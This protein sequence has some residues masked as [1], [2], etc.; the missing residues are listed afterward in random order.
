[1]SL[2]VS[3]VLPVVHVPF[4]DD[5]SIDYDSL[6]RLIEWAF[7][8]GAS[9][10]CTGMVS[11]LLRLTTA[12]RLELTEK[13]GEFN[14][15][16]GMVVIGSGAEST[17]QAI[18]Y[19]ECAERSGC[20]AVMVIPPISSGL[21][22]DAVREYFG[23]IADAVS[24]PMIVQDA[25]GY[26]GKEIPL[27]VSRDLLERYGEDKVLFKPEASPLGPKLSLLRDATGGRAK[28]LEG[29]GGFAL[30]DSY[31][32]GIVGTIPG[33]EFLPAIVRLWRALREGDEPTTY[34][35]YLPLCALVSLQLQAGLDGFLAIEKYLMNQYGIFPNTNRRKPY[36]WSLDEETRQELHR[37][38]GLLDEALEGSDQE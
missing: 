34:R 35:I 10:Y 9:G 6:E 13:L 32:R 21:P 19:A 2:S 26:V 30:V 1:M 17:K 36:S 3:G 14:R 23:A 4:H 29:S 8:Q 11:E 22:A 12:E 16:R 37:L 31:R 7:E 25:S 15:G 18:Q 5:D 38:L 20:G 24:L 27:V 33:M 28:I